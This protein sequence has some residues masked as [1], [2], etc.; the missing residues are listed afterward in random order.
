MVQKSSVRTCQTGQIKCYCTLNIYNIY[1]WFRNRRFA[2][3]KQAKWNVIALRTYTIYTNGSEIAGSH[4]SN[5]PN[6]MWLHFE[7]IHCI[8]TV[9]KSL[10]RTCQRHKYKW[11]STSNL[12]PVHLLIKAEHECT[13]GWPGSIP[14]GISNSKCHTWICA[15]FSHRVTRSRESKTHGFSSTCGSTGTWKY[16]RVLRVLQLFAEHRMRNFP[17]SDRFHE[18]HRSSLNTCPICIILSAFERRGHSQDNAS[19]NNAK[20]LFFWSW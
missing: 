9:Q 14:M 20:I 18:I 3:V 1:E 10:V 8:P 11:H 5:R 17:I 16:W 13:R 2:H 12:Q 15:G 7:H 6:K 4:M 19:F